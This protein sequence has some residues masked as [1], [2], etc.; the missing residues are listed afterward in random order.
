MNWDFVN[1]QL[2]INTNV[3]KTLPHLTKRSALS[4]IASIFDPLGRLSSLIMQA[5]FIIQQVWMSDR[6][7]KPVELAKAWDEE[8]PVELQASFLDV[9]IM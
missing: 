1:D 2:S 7:L 6:A 3:S 5:R 4:L 8:I 9:M